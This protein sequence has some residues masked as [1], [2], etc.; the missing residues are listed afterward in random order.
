MN[1]RVSF[2]GALVCAAGA[3]FGGGDVPVPLAWNWN[4]MVHSGESGQPDNPDGFRSISDRALDCNG[5]A[6]AINN[7]ALV[8]QDSLLYSVVAVAGAFDIVHLGSTGVTGS[9]RGW[10]ATVDGDNIGVRPNWL[11]T[12]DQSTPQRSD[13]LAMQ[14][15]FTSSTRLGVLYNIS[16]SGGAF[17][18]TLEFGDGSTATVRLAGPDW[19]G[20]QT[21]AAPGSGVEVQRQLGLFDATQSDDSGFT[22]A[23]QLNVVEAIVSTQS[24]INAGLGDATGKRLIGITFKNPVPATRGYAIYAATLRANTFND[25]PVSPT[26]VGAANPSPVETTRNVTLRVQ[27]VGGASPASTGL[28]VTV[29]TSAIGGSG[30]QTMLDDGNNGD[31]AAGDGVFGLIAPIPATQFL[32]ATTVPFTVSDAQGRSFAGSINFTVNQYTWNETLDGGGDAGDLPD[33]ATAPVGTGTLEAIAG[34]ISAG[35]RDMYAIEICDSTQFSASTQGGTTLDTQLFLFNEQG[36][37]VA[38]SDDAAPG[39]QS[40]ITSQFIPSNG[41]YYLAVSQYD[42]DPVNASGQ[43]MWL[44]QPF[45]TE[46]AP[47]GPGAGTAI[48]GWNGTQT[49]SAAYRITLTGACFAGPAGCDDIDFNN[50]DVFPEDQDVIDFFE[51]LAGADCPSCN[52]I[53]FN[54]NDVFPE[55]QDVIDFFNVLAGGECV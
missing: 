4:G 8:G 16:N 18:M 26:G 24:L 49:G 54:N 51:V 50:N 11:T 44:D 20:S 28:G 45:G 32:G 46:R 19:F 48:A 31:G 23:P 40:R 38:F 37:P 17:D 25:S 53:D 36:L 29:D 42:R 3:A 22:G 21:V 34:N 9:V 5:G 52:D 13:T 27:A 2:V 1:M 41:R 43:E 12:L 10:D 33:T 47:D 15:G 35:D 14:T 55:D 6:T 39:T 30:V 7:G